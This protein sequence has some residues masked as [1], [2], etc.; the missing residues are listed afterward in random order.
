LTDSRRETILSAA[1]AVWGLAIAI[2][3]FTIWSRP[4]PP[5]QLPGLSKSW[6][7]DARRP[8]WLVFGM[9]AA[10]LVVPLAFRPVIRRLARG[11]AW[12]RNATMAAIGSSA[13]VAT[14]DRHALFTVVPAA[15]A[16]AL[17][18]F[19]RD[20]DLAFT[21]HDFVLIPVF[22]GT[23]VAVL[24]V[25]P[26]ILAGAALSIAGLIVF[27]LRIAVALIPRPL[28]PAF[29]FLA[30]P[31]AL[32]FQTIFMG[33]EERFFGWH[34]LALVV[35]SP[36]ILRLTLRNGRRA[37]S[38]L[39]LVIY[40]LSLYCFE[41]VRNYS[42]AHNNLYV[43]FFEDG[44]SL[45][46]AS[47]FLAGELPYRDVNPGH[48]LLEDGYFDYLAMK[49][50]GETL[51]ARTKARIAVGTLAIV[52]IYSLGFAA[53][54]SPHVGLLAALF[55][56]F[57]GMHA[58]NL[59]FVAATFTLALIAGAV[60]RRDPRRFGWAGFMS[61]I[62]GLVS[63][64]FAFYTFVTLVVAV[65]RARP[66]RRAGQAAAIG[67]AAGAVPLFTVFLLS[68]ILDDFLRTTFI[69]LPRI[70]S[71]YTLP[72]TYFPEFLVREAAFPD[73]LNAWFDRLSLPY[74]A[75]C[76]IVVFLGIALPRRATRRIEPLIVI[77]LWTALAS[78]SWAER[79]HVYFNFMIAPLL[80]A[81]ITVIP[82]SQRRFAIG[83]VVAAVIIA[84]PA[85]QLRFLHTL[86]GDRG[87]VN[88]AG[89][90][91][92]F[93]LPRA[94]GV[95]M[96]TKDAAVVQI[97][98]KYVTSSLRPDETFLDFT[99]SGMLYFLLERDC[100]VRQSEVGF[101]SH[102]DQQR[103]VIRRV[104]SNAKVRAVLLPPH[105]TGRVTVDGVSNMERAPLVWQYINTHFQPDFAE[106][107]VVMWRRK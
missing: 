100:P 62:C 77:G 87:R 13:I 43:N 4:A 31:L 103:E 90:S 66:F 83:A 97:V 78:I 14:L 106:G 86:R 85:A 26:R 10:P 17:C 71:A 33:R 3:F 38:V 25:W 57:T 28:P 92:L 48:G 40:P 5:D 60:R 29:A 50:H 99:N 105:Q 89:Y 93:E 15:L 84:R 42:T 19:L 94:R 37:A 56:M 27:G 58:S 51:G 23:Y 81:A 101:F 98:N 64:D 79:Q 69:E 102:P 88:P 11:R 49:I 9:M 2:S 61:V 39:A 68:G 8:Y 52:G 44:H 22:L 45:M 70:S 96:E 34:G 59:R 55:A 7:I 30:A 82:R 46:P 21:K 65:A 53:T 104:Q 1:F 72:V 80:I 63:L 91:Q 47:E 76:L 54:S 16:I 67:I 41:N 12:S 107:D 36:F 35:V 18:T 20:R 73:A 24:D 75:W 74:L 95:L 32:A 6:N